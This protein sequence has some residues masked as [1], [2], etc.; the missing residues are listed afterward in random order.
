MGG[1]ADN[2]LN[3]A[4]YA[5]FP[6]PNR[7]GISP[8]KRIA[9]WVTEAVA[10]PAAQRI[11]ESVN[12]SIDDAEINRRD[13]RAIGRVTAT[14][15]FQRLAVSQR[16]DKDVDRARLWLVE[17]L[18]KHEPA[19]LLGSRRWVQTDTTR[20]VDASAVLVS[21]GTATYFLDVFDIISNDNVALLTGYGLSLVLYYFGSRILLRRRPLLPRQLALRLTVLRVLTRFL[22]SSLKEPIDETVDS[23]RAAVARLQRY[24]VWDASLVIDPD[25]LEHRTELV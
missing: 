2:R 10:S 24:Y 1:E 19:A 22:A 3:H 11:F 18:R 12:E 5:P 23:A 13:A 17:E 8:E 16:H 15:F 7:G 9:A 21:G 6:R 25:Q 14:V 4:V 20:T